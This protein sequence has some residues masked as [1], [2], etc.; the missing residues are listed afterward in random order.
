MCWFPTR[1][2]FPTHQSR[3]RD[4]VHYTNQSHLTSCFWRVKPRVQP[5]YIE[6]CCLPWIN[7]CES[8]ENPVW[9]RHDVTGMW[10]SEFK[11]HPLSSWHPF[12]I[13]ITEP[14]PCFCDPSRPTLPCLGLI[15]KQS[16]TSGPALL[17]MGLW[18]VLGW[19][20]SLTGCSESLAFTSGQ[21]S[22][23]SC[24]SGHSRLLI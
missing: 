18:M 21:N 1:N 24:F 7:S 3:A 12:T 23:S 17:P 16:W 4:V 19:Q 13:I 14:Q 6:T 9:P 8:K 20:A 2:S 11:T 22:H 5:L 10:A 15:S